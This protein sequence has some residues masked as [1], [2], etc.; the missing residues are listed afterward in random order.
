MD[1]SGG[2]T[3]AENEVNVTQPRCIS[4]YRIASLDVSGK[5]PILFVLH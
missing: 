2:R 4:K 5:M 3:L 1:M